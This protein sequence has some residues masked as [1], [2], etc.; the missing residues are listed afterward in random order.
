MKLVRRLFI[1]QIRGYQRFISPHLPAACR[2]TPTCSR[3]AVD[4]I[5]RFGVIPGIWLGTL[6]IC[7]CNPWSQGGWDPVPLT[8]APGM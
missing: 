5:N 6:R 7:R 2:Y 3:Y 4:A 8:A 1:L